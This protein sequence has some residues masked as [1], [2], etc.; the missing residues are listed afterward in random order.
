MRRSR[1]RFVPPPLA[2]AIAEVNRYTSKPFVIREEAPAQVRV[3]GVFQITALQEFEFAL[4]ESLRLHVV[5]QGGEI[6]IRGPRQSDAE[7]V[8]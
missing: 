4:R 8:P 1:W 5:D 6:V 7:P 2:A 3:S